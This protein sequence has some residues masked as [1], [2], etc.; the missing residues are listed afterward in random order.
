MG[1]KS[2]AKQMFTE[3]AVGHKDDDERDDV[4]YWYLI[5]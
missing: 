2:E 5:Q 1:K 4:A 3:A